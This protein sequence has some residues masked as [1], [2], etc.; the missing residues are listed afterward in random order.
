MSLAQFCFENEF[1]IESEIIT[2]N[3]II[4]PLILNNLTLK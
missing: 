1:L 4:N 2:L 3:N